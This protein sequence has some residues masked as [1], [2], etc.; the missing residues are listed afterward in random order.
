MKRCAIYLLLPVLC[1]LL[2]GASAAAEQMKP[3]MWEI[4]STMEMPG[5]PFQPPAQTIRH[6]YTAQDVQQSPVPSDSSCEVSSLK[7][8]GNKVSWTVDCSGDM[9]GSGKGEIVYQSDSAYSG[10][11]SIT[12]EG[13]SMKTK[14]KA[15]RIGNCK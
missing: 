13:M 5:M 9:K 7:H 12:T 11:M 3:G 2:P 8:I 10:T 1:L 15:K 14:Y 4:T 6:C